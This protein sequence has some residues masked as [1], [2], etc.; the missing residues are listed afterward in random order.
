[1]C[2]D[3]K[4]GFNSVN[5]NDLMQFGI[6]HTIKSTILCSNKHTLVLLLSVKNN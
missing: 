5:D 2:K 6:G 1:M 4:T 3:M